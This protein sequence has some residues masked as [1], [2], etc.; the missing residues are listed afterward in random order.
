[1]C[2]GMDLLVEA[3]VAMKAVM[4]TRKFV[5]EYTHLAECKHL[6]VIN[7]LNIERPSP[8]LQVRRVNEQARLGELQRQGAISAVICAAQAIQLE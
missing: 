2:R 5:Q 8:V 3:A 6:E 1:M 4:T 7:R